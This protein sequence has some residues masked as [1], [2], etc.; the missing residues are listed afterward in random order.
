MSSCAI[1]VV[2]DEEE[3]RDLI[4]HVLER[5]GYSVACAANGLEAS[6]LI[7]RCQF[8]VVVTDMLMPDRD[9]LELITE[10]KAKHP[11]LKIVAMSGGGQI[12]SDQYLSMA[13]GFGAHVL[14][15]KPFAYQALLAAVDRAR[16]GQS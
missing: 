8:D 13:K 6:L 5:A 9:G 2:D 14:L 4:R 1:L 15:R 16:A 10:I 11:A 7:A 3:L 12:G